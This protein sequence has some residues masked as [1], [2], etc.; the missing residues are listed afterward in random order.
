MFQNAFD[1]TAVTFIFSLCFLL[2]LSACSS[3]PIFSMVK[4]SQ[5]D[6][7]QMDP[8]QIKIAVITHN[9][10]E[11]KKGDVTMSLGY[12]AADNSLIIEDIYLVE[13]SGPDFVDSELAKQLDDNERLTIMHLSPADAQQLRDSQRLISQHQQS[14]EKGQG[15][16]SVGINGSCTTNSLPEDE[17]LVNIFLQP[18]AQTSFIKVIDDLD[19]YEQN[20]MKELKNWPEC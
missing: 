13:V 4:L 6:P 15:S 8:N 2:T 7:F 17:L 19:L 18:D 16:F 10:L 5:L 11:V 20:E 3:I 9:A 14:G 12:T 1:K